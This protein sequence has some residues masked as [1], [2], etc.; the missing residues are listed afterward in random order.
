[1]LTAFEKG[2]LEL[3]KSALK[4][5]EPRLDPSFDIEAAYS[6]AQERQI[7]PL[8]YYGAVNIP[9]IMDSQTGKKMFMSTMNIGY[10]CSQQNELIEK[11]KK[12][13][14]S[15]SIQY[16]MVKGTVIRSLY[17]YPEMRI[18]SDADI[19]IKQEQYPR[20][21]EI[22]LSLGM[23]EEYE[24]DH[25]LV[26]KKDGFT[27]ELHKH[28]IPTYNKDYYS[29]FG[30]GWRLAKEINQAGECKMTPENSFIYSFVH[31]AMHYRNRGIGVKH[32][33]DF[34]VIL[35]NTPSLD[36]EYIEAEL[37]KLN[38]LDFWR[39]T[40]VLID[41]WF[42]E[43]EADERTVFMT[44]KIFESGTFGTE[45]NKVKSEAIRTSNTGKFMKV[46]KIFSLL[47]PTYKAM[48]QKYKVLKKV[49]ILLPVMWV[50]RWIST[51]FTPSKIKNQKRQL[52]LLT[53]DGVDKYREELLYVGLDFQQ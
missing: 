22:M 29:Y 48:C 19:L 12:A 9:N 43:R 30:D 11:I 27:V 44:K 7:T 34:Y 49:P 26:W 42:G 18:M 20:I 37:E 32:V 31:Y 4:G 47:F 41:V 2:I 13:F 38:L 17:P 21:R 24:S 51:L 36:M 33:T 16:L 52:D 40:K 45:E 23:T 6:F 39:Y 5:T 15:G 1:M 8:I 3:I 50:A 10:Y 28:L 35:E 25:E 14:D 53:K 46:K